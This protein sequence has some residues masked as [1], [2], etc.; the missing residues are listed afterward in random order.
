MRRGLLIVTSMTIAVMTIAT[1]LA[2]AAELAIPKR[3]PP[4]GFSMQ[5][6]PPNC[7]RWTDECV[8]CARGATSGEAPVCS[9]IGFACQPKAIRCLMPEASQNKQKK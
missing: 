9:N 2:V 7:A 4:A 8:N 5:K 1:E 6:G 3:K